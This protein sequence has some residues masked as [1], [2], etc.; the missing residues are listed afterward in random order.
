VIRGWTLRSRLR[1]KLEEMFLSKVGQTTAGLPSFGLIEEPGIMEAQMTRIRPLFGILF[2]LFSSTAPAGAQSATRAYTA[3][4]YLPGCKDFIAGKSNFLGG[5]C[6][7]VVE[8]LDALSR[9]TK[10]FCAPE[11]TNNLERVRVII[12]YIEA[13][14]ERTK[15]DFRLLANEAMARAWP[16]KN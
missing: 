12:A 4:F 8:V 15:E 6:V 1:G 3:E 5:R 16:C 9:D 13:R 2:A 14:P 10:A 7:G 11:A